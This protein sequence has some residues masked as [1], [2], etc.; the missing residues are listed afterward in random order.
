LS[1][2]PCDLMISAETAE[3]QAREFGHSIEIEMKV[4]ALHGA[5]HLMGYDHEK[6]RGRMARMEREWRTR[7]GLPVMSLIE[8]SA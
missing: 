1:F 7:L 4:L 3:R 6:D 8:R 2:E 5:L